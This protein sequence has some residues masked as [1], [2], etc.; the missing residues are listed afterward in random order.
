[1]GP[2]FIVGSGIDCFCHARRFDNKRISVVQ[3]ELNRIDA[4]QAV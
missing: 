3:S 4:L 1:L 2:D